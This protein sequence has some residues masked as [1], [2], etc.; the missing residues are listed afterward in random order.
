MQDDASV[1][2]KAC[3]SPSQVNSWWT[4]LLCFSGSCN[5]WGGPCF[6]L[7]VWASFQREITVQRAKS[8]PCA[9]WK[10]AL[11]CWVCEQS[12][13]G[14]H[15]SSTQGWGGINSRRLLPDHSSSRACVCSAH[16]GSTGGVSTWQGTGPC[17]CVL[18]LWEAEGS[19][20]KAGLS[21][22]TITNSIKSSWIACQ[23]EFL[24]SS[25]T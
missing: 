23:C 14:S 18:P 1:V 9:C 17:I 5:Q 19:V 21:S 15:G 11:W 22:F 7:Q 2:K 8:S 13:A 12:T 6:M 10:A 3:L 24:R 4:C 16:L 20:M 25:I